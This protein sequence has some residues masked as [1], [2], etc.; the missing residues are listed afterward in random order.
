MPPCLLTAILPLQDTKIEHIGKDEFVTEQG[1]AEDKQEAT[2][3]ATDLLVLAAKTEE[4]AAALEV[5]TFALHR[6]CVCNSGNV[7][8]TLALLVAMATGTDLR[9]TWSG[10]ASMASTARHTLPRIPHPPPFNASQVWVVA[11]GE[12]EDGSGAA[13]VQAYVHHDI[14]LSAFP[15]SVAWSDFNPARAQLAGSCQCAVRHYG[16]HNSQRVLHFDR[17]CT[18]RGLIHGFSKAELAPSRCM[19]LAHICASQHATG[20]KSCGALSQVAVHAAEPKTAGNFAAVSTFEPEIEIWDLD[21]LDVL[22]PALVL[23]GRKGKRKKKASK[24]GGS[25]ASTEKFKPGS[26]TDSVLCLAW[27]AHFRNG[28][29]SG[30]A[31]HTI[32]VR[33]E[34]CYALHG[35]VLHRL[36][37]RLALCSRRLQHRSQ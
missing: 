23:G 30:S 15:L 4:D 24:R 20:M 21:V 1:A 31:D 28:L 26:H 27:N 13:E 32:K 3:Q 19:H 37:W 11:E 29:A 12:A 25:K 7:T 14:M 5:S 8:S 16:L 36:P 18:C 10:D 6:S 22:K 33:I 34:C 2:L 35:G 9:L 17:F